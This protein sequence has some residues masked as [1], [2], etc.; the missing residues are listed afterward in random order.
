M[1][2]LV[3]GD[4]QVDG[5]VANKL[6]V[7]QW[8]D[9]Y[10]IANVRDRFILGATVFHNWYPESG[11]VE[12]SCFSEN[13]R[14]LDLKMINAVFGYA[15]DHLKCQLVVLRVSE[16]NTRMMDIAERLG[17]GGY[18]IPRLRGKNEAEWI[19]TMTDDT[20]R[21]SPLRSKVNG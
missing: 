15:F 10:S 4:E 6:G 3:Y 1:S 11:V 18:L 20:W 14:W 19:Y 9:S 7:R 8:S 17:F 2:E 12:L 16:I 5:W 13:P 21:K